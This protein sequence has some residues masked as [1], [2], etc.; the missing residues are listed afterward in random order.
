MKCELKYNSNKLIA[1]RHASWMCMPFSNLLVLRAS[2]EVECC[3]RNF[4]LYDVFNV[5]LQWQVVKHWLTEDGI[6]W[7]ELTTLVTPRAKPTS[8]LPQ[9]WYPSYIVPTCPCL[10]RASCLTLEINEFRC[11]TAKIEE[12]E[13]A[14]SLPVTAGL[15]KLIHVHVCQQCIV[16]GWG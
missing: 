13:K 10:L 7:A 15:F 8:K 14:G 2:L 4:L 1:Y 9:V 3:K 5:F 16:R 11:Y 12:S 6:C